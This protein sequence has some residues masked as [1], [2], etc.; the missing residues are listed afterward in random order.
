M[1]DA[2]RATISA[3]V[4][5]RR[6][7]LAEMELRAPHDGVLR[8]NTNWDGS[9][10]QV[11]TSVWAGDDFAA[12]PDLSSLIARF[13]LPQS[14]AD[15][16]KKDHRVH[17]RVAGSGAQFES[18]VV[19]VGASASIKSRESPVKYID[20]DAEITPEMLA[21]AA[22]TPGQA[23]SAEVVLIDRQNV[24][25]VPNAAL[26][27]HSANAGEAAPSSVSSGTDYKVEA[28]DGSWLIV[29]LGEQGGVMSEIKSGVSA[30]TAIKLM[31]S[32]GNELKPDAVGKPGQ[33]DR[34]SRE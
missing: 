31:P 8:L 32:T 7:S 15:G 22:L 9:R 28:A 17:L 23:L 20:F 18:R 14:Q 27:V 13:S 30:G 19:R 2:Q 26:V 1:T 16:L 11:G 5:S 3:A 6:A 34:G 25:V 29:Q 24:L 33:R 10:A 12:L 21:A 4:N